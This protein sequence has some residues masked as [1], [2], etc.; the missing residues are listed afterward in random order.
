MQPLV[1]TGAPGT[2]KTTLLHALAAQGYRIVH[3]SARELIR[4]RVEKGL[5][6][7]P[8]PADFARQLLQKDAE[9]YETAA[10]ESGLVFFD[11]GVVDAL[12]MV[13][14]VAPLPQHEIETVVSRYPYGTVFLLPLWEAIYSSD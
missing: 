1:F 11:R 6:P 5:A 2:G 13:N 7:R 10:S 8:A 4:G 9:K 12:G 3:E 14:D